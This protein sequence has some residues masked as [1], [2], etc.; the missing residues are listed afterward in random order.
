VTGSNGGTLATAGNLVFQGTAD[1][2]FVAYRASDGEK[3]WESPAGTGVMAAPVTYAVGGVQYVAVA[4]GWGAAFALSA[5]E[6]ALRA[7]VRGG[8]RV[9][10]FALGGKAPVPPGLPPLGPPPVPTFQLQATDAERRRGG[11]LYQH[12]CAACHGPAAI[13]GGSGIPDLRYASSEVHEH[14]D[15]IAR[16]GLR[17]SGGMP[18]FADRLT[19]EDARA[20]QAFV[21]ERARESAE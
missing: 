11:E 12:R 2:R 9:L 21:L 20:I 5:G 19:K 14:W 3:L 15:E 7:G 8:G 1:G 4:A 17:V 13:G 16:G 18:P 6:A 10:A